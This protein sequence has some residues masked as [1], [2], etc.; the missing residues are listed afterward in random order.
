MG[1]FLLVTYLLLSI[2]FYFLFPKMGQAAWQG[3]VPGLNLVIVCRLIGRKDAHAAWLLF[4]LVN[5]FIFAGMMV[6]L[7]RSFNK[8]LFWHSVLAVIAAPFYFMYLALS[9]KEKYQGPILPKEQ[10]YRTQ[11]EQARKEKKTRQ[12][13]K[14]EQENPYKKSGLREWTESIIFAVFAAALIRMFLIEAYMIPTSSMEGSMMVGD[15]LFVS[16]ASYGVRTPETVAMV[17]LLHNRLPFGDSESYF[18]RPRLKP[19]RLPALRQIKHNSPVVFNFPAGDSVYVFANRTW[20]IEDYRYGALAGTEAQRQIESGSKPLVTRPTDKKDHYIKRCVGLPGDT[21]Q[22]INRDIWI[23]GEKQ[24]NPSGIQYI[25]HVSTPNGINTNAFSN[26]GISREDILKNDPSSN[27]MLLIL[28]EKQAEQLRTL[29][30]AI[31]AA[32]TM[33]YLVNTPQGYNVSRLFEL[34]L[35]MSG[36]RGELGPNSLFFSLTDEQAASLRADSALVVQN[37]ELNKQRLFPH[38]P[39]QFP[40]WTIDNF[41]PIFIPQKGASIAMTPENLSL[42]RRVIEVYE[43]NA[44]AVKEGQVWING[45]ASDTYT[46]QMDYYWM[47]GDNRHNSEDSRIWGFV[48]EDHVVGMPLFIWFSLREGSLSNG[49]NWSRIGPVAG[50]LK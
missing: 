17:P 47:M 8:M 23:N 22:I 2:S 7:V 21:L 10:A 15:F 43:G 36:F 18:K 32:P 48:P 6:D 4:P 20:T 28:S 9:D 49:I 37:Y 11:L 25:Y 26:W 41:G 14:L 19:M 40:G 29:D 33:E 44:V 39:A 27:S 45:T 12:V 13:Q 31:V 30:P 42:Y 34:G 3:L 50:K 38:D 46:F 16:K 5:V 1:I 24:T 35:D